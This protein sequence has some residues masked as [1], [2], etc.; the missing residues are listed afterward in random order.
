[1]AIAKKHGHSDQEIQ[2]RLAFFGGFEGMR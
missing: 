2:E 1:V